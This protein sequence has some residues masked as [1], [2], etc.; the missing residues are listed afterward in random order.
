[1][2]RGRH[3]WCVLLLLL[4]GCENERP[5]HCDFGE[6][7][8]ELDHDD[9]HF[10]ALAW[11]SEGGVR[12]ALYSTPDGFYTRT[13]SPDAT[14]RRVGPA[15]MSLSLAGDYAFC[16]VGP[17]PAKDIEGQIVAYPLATLFD[18]S[19]AGPLPLRLAVGAEHA[20]LAAAR[21]PQGTYELVYHDGRP[22]AFVVYH[23]ALDE[24]L[25]AEGPPS[26]L[27]APRVNAGAPDIVF[28][29]DE[30]FITWPETWST[31]APDYDHI[32]G[33]LL[34]VSTRASASAHGAPER[35]AEIHHAAAAP[36][37]RPGPEGNVLLF[38]DVRPP[39]RRAGLF[40]M[41]IDPR[42]EPQRIG[43]SSAPGAIHG[44]ECAGSF[45]TATPRSY[46]SDVLIAL[47]LL[48]AR[49][50]DRV[51]EQQVY[52]WAGRFDD[53]AVRCEDGEV[54]MLIAQQ[55]DTRGEPARLHE[56]DLRCE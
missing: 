52:E 4:L 41:K 1:M 48:D 42:T 5:F 9:T 16:A 46:G 20:G 51:P 12:L 19:E 28:I 14:P 37:V 6:E 8:L 35:V 25:E 23:V 13:M 55:G 45:V 32:E 26:L 18:A 47:H 39:I 43:R 50:E 34:L 53:V 10:G 40:A 24:D 44:I 38:R 2:Q 17:A 31:Y 11:A 33:H 3:T 36:V 54:Q 15:C 56:L 21:S 22:G 30:R 49:L 27:S 7:A 29:G